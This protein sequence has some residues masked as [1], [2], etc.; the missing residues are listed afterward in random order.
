MEAQKF[1]LIAVL[2]TQLGLGGCA[3][4]VLDQAKEDSGTA[5]DA[6]LADAGQ[7]NA[8]AQPDA[9]VGSAA[10]FPMYVTYTD[11]NDDLQTYP[12]LGELETP[13]LEFLFDDADGE[14]E[15]RPG[16]VCLPFADNPRF[17]KILV[18]APASDVVSCEARSSLAPV[19]FVCPKVIIDMINGGGFNVVLNT[20]LWQH[21]G[22]DRLEVMHWPYSEDFFWEATIGGADGSSTTKTI[23]LKKLPVP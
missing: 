17:V 1:L 7:T 22:C 19:P 3:S 5:A 13:V 2:F 14:F 12:M 16:G 20:D 9:D 18:R 6:Q 8:D 4:S 23:Y 21:D 10:N 11:L 15:Y